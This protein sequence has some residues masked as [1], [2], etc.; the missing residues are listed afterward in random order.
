M[1][2]VSR[3]E[4]EALMAVVESLRERVEYLEPESG[5]N[6]IADGLERMKV[7]LRELRRGER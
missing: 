4:F 5:E 7:R 3:Q 6:R 2:E 1:S